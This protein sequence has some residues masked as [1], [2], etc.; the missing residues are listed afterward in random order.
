MFSD[1]P[2]LRTLC[3]AEHGDMDVLKDMVEKNHELLH[4]RDSD[5]YTPLHRASYNG[6][7]NALQV[8]KKLNNKTTAII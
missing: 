2:V 8:T 4:C 7:L 5:G 6:H 3:A 1:S